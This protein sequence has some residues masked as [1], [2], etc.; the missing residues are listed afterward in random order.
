MLA[1]QLIFF[2]FLFTAHHDGELLCLRSCTKTNLSDQDRVFYSLTRKRRLAFHEW[3]LF[4]PAKRQDVTATSTTK[5]DVVVCD[6]HFKQ[7]LPYFRGREGVWQLL[8]AANSSNTI[9][10]AH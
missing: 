9:A 5:S 10:K 4:V 8:L 7:K 3:M 1:V 2:S 6:A